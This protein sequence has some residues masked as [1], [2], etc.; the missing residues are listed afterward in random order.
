M[1]SVYDFS[2][3]TYHM[4]NCLEIP[5]KG[6]YLLKSPNYLTIVRRF[7]FKDNPTALTSVTASICWRGRYWNKLETLQLTA[8]SSKKT[9]K[10][11]FSMILAKLG[12]FSFNRRNTCNSSKFTHLLWLW[13]SNLNWQLIWSSYL[14]K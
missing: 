4:K 14:V 9:S 11:N 6:P 13:Y 3:A 8:V 10:G 2:F 12:E 7:F 5:C 1:K